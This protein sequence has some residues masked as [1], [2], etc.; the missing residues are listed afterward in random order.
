MKTLVESQLRDGRIFGDVGNEE[1]IYVPS[2]EIGMEE[3]V[4]IFQRGTNREDV[5]MPE[6]LRL[7]QRYGL[8]LVEHPTMG[9][10]SV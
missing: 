9:K 6:A 2:S 1:Y 3:P 7:I 4:C 8:E 5:T 10:S